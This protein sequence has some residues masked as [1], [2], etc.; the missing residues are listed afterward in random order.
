MGVNRVARGARDIRNHHALLAQQP[1]HQRGFAH[2][3]FADDRDLHGLVFLFSL[4]R[5]WEEFAHFLQQIAKVQQVHRR[6]ANRVAHAQL[7]E[8]V[9]I[10]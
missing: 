2:V 3:R 8:I 9:H 10:I 7:I 5:V 4:L 1:V 6:H